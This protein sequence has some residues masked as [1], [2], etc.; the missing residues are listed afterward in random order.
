MFSEFDPI[1]KKTWLQKA[2]KDLKGK[3]L[4]KL[5]WKTFEGDDLPP[6]Y[7]RSDLGGNGSET[8]LPG[9]FPYVRG[10][11]ELGNGW[12]IRE[13]ITQHKNFAA[14]NKKAL[15]AVE[16]GAH[17]LVFNIGAGET[18]FSG[19]PVKD[20]EDLGNLLSGLDP[21]NSGISF[22]SGLT[23]PFYINL[24][25]NWVETNGHSKTSIFG[26]A[27]YDPLG[28]MLLSG[29]SSKPIN[30][31]FDELSALFS[32]TH[33]N[34]PYYKCLTIQSANFHNSGASL[35]QELAFTLALAHEYIHHLSEKSLAI[36]GLL[37]NM[38]IELST[39]GSYFQEIAKIRAMRWLWTTVMQ[40][41]TNNEQAQA[42]YIVGCTSQ[43][44]KS[45]YDPYVNMLR[46]T[47]EGMAMAIGGADEMQIDG[48]DKTFKAT[49]EFSERISRNLHHLLIH[50]SHLDKS[51]DPS[52]GSYY[53]E[54]LTERLATEALE[55]F[56]QVEAKGGL[57]A[58]ARSGWLQEQLKTSRKKREQRL[59][60]RREKFLGVNEFPNPEDK[61][62]NI[63][64]REAESKPYFGKDEAQPNNFAM[65]AHIHEFV[66]YQYQG[67]GDKVEPLPTYA[68][69]EAFEQLRAQV[70]LMDKEGKKIPSFFLMPLG[71][72][73]MRT[74]R[75]N[76][77]L[78]LYQCGGF[79]VLDHPGFNSVTEA[80]DAF[81]TSGADTVVIC[82]SDNEYEDL[83]PQVGRT[84]KKAG[85]TPKLV[86]AGHPKDKREDYEDMGI[87]EFIYA[88][89]DIYT[90]LSNQLIHE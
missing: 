39:G 68:A 8:L 17:N 3:P 56:K 28:A 53:I 80:V 78:N 83:I 45:V 20:L 64:Q 63:L 47:T 54:Q 59:A 46:L 67:N 87:E 44:N 13:E 12:L 90:L 26:G 57:L 18:G 22:K 52:S 49:D 19:I 48:Y 11:K 25:S 82:S 72:R 43:W 16:S 58:T 79:S 75:A 38:Q 1:N 9:Q 85:F 84:L 10:H 40:E 51:I 29:S 89:C 37:A 35:V 7:T 33:E 61:I 32:F 88:G 70:D 23:A 42:C 14:T 31:I 81:K 74:A 15:N 4:E 27:D 34:L 76:F 41:Y 24:L 50:E 65:A 77:A 69:T 21:Q 71:N 36:D 30:Q 2:E 73:T 66:N 60:T 55:L 86:L 62:Y 6:F 5:N